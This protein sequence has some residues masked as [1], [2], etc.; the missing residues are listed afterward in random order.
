MSSHIL[1]N[2]EVTNLIVRDLVGLNAVDQY[3]SQAPEW[4]TKRIFPNVLYSAIDAKKLPPI[5]IEVV[6]V[7]NS[8]FLHQVVQY[9][10]E[11]NLRYG[12][13]PLVLIFVVE[14]VQD[15][16]T[17]NT[18]R[19]YK[20]PFLLKLPSFPWAKDCFVVSKSSIQ[21]HL[22]DMPLHP[23]V[24]LAIFFTTQKPDL[25]DHDPTIQKLYNILKKTSENVILNREEIAYDISRICNDF[26]SRLDESV[27]LLSRLKNTES[28]KRAID[29]LNG[30]IATLVT[31]KRKYIP[32]SS[33]ELSPLTSS[34]SRSSVSLVATSPS[35]SE[36]WNFVERFI[37]DYDKKKMDWKACYSEGKRQG[38]FTNYTTHISLKNSYQRWKIQ[39]GPPC[40]SRRRTD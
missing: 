40:R 2:A 15:D 4:S 3:L 10:E 39:H 14:R 36:N 20:Y 5:V 9:C 7:V 35:L 34:S 21:G 37:K 17:S 30:G 28:K 24:A 8:N 13:V 29:C 32:N 6:H 18:T 33:R 23:L 38:Y 27:R 16:I 11:V 25:L 31:Y 22:T 12:V 26:E 1:L 19:H